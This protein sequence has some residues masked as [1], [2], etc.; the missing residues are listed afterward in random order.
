ML[1][2]PTAE[3][4]PSRGPGSGGDS[5]EAARRLAVLFERRDGATM[6]GPGSAG[7][8]LVQVVG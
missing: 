1:W 8:G 2:A 5:S 7:G 6:V 3:L 4:S